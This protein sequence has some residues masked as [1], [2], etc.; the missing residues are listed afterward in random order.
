MTQEALASDGQV[1][2]DDEPSDITDSFPGADGQGNCKNFSSSRTMELYVEGNLS[3][4]LKWRRQKE[5]KKN[6]CGK[7]N[8]QAGKMYSGAGLS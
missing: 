4:Y 3:R 7:R 2:S 8:M 1:P 6:E 5:T